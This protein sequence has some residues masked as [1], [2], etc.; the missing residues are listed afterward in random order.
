MRNCTSH[1]TGG[2]L[3]KWPPEGKKQGIRSVSWR[4][5]TIKES[6]MGQLVSISDRETVQLTY[7]EINFVEQ[8]LL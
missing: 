3:K 1:G 8:D 6:M 4:N 5:R 2:R 7:D